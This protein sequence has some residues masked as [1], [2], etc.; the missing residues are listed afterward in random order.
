[1][2]YKHLTG[3]ALIDCV[4]MT[5]INKKRPGEYSEPSQTSEMELFVK[6]VNDWIIFAKGSILDVW[7]GSNT[8]LKTVSQWKI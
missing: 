2:K 7:L 8:L 3:L 6:I 4:N 1:M 5:T